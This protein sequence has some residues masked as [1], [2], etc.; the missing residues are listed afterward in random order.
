[1]IAKLDRNIKKYKKIGQKEPTPISAR[2]LL[3]RKNYYLCGVFSLNCL[4]Q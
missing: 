2:F 4:L 3:F 1:M